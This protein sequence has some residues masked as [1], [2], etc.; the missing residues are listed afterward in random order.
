MEPPQ[1]IHLVSNAPEH[2]EN[3]ASKFKVSYNLPFSLKNKKIALIDAT[4]T[5][6]QQ[7][8]LEEKI[9]FQFDETPKS[10][11]RTQ[12][13]EL[14]DIGLGDTKTNLTAFFKRY[15]KD[16]YSM[17]DTTAPPILLGSC[18][19]TY[20]EAD[21]LLQITVINKSAY[22]CKIEIKKGKWVLKS[23][24]EASGD[25]YTIDVAPKTS[26]ILKF[27]TSGINYQAIG[28]H[29]DYKKFLNSMDFR[30]YFESVLVVT[31]PRMRNKEFQPGPNHFATIKELIK[32]IN[33][34]EGF[35]EW[36]KL[37]LDH[38]KVQFA[39]KRVIDKCN[40]H[41]GGLQHHLGFDKD[42]LKVDERVRRFKANRPPNL[43]GGT[44]HFF[45]YCSLVKNVLV[46]NSLVPLLC[47]LD[48]TKGKYGEQVM[49]PVVHP[50][51]VEA[52]EGPHQ[53]IEIVIADD[54][55]NQQN[56]LMFRTKLTLSVEDQ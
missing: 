4:F 27:D 49:H 41:L 25:S 23:E 54:T 3:T 21:N 24:G 52:N 43:S 36:A 39:I 12:R 55:G 22:T 34:L 5:K 18:K 9:K 42:I 6:S 8:V 46:N 1:V 14:T 38:G 15:T 45:I 37:S 30:V 20:S 28:D 53:T 11:Y 51:F 10:Y 44:H 7:N 33:N 50:L 26:K 16:F 17:T 31:H 47:T 48:A 13:Y 35:S 19:H 40:I 32:T 2:P 29:V 56:L